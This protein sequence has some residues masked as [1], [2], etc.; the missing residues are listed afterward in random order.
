MAAS[1]GSVTF[2]ADRKDVE[3]I[4]SKCV[5]LGLSA[6][7]VVMGAAACGSSAP[8]GNTEGTGQGGAATSGSSSD[9][10]GG[11]HV[12]V[13]TS[14]TGGPGGGSSCTPSCGGKQCGDDGCGSTCGICAGGSNCTASN[15]CEVA[16]EECP[17]SGDGFMR[18]YPDTWAEGQCIVTWQCGNCGDENQSVLRA[19]SHQ[20]GNVL[21][22]KKHKTNGQADFASGGFLSNLGVERRESILFCE[23][24]PSGSDCVRI[25]VP[26]CAPYL[27]KPS[28]SILFNWSFNGTPVRLRRTGTKLWA[29]SQDP[30]NPSSWGFSSAGWLDASGGLGVQDAGYFC[31]EATQ[32]AGAPE[33][34][35]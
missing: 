34:C 32:P 18:S 27:A 13:S 14:S 16:P 9:G 19:H 29:E 28:C 22:A 24:E 30:N 5:Y 8:G 23:K 20:P 10:V 35:P 33:A 31:F 7:G 3:M 1:L 12:N 11:S 21:Y 15:Q 26:D 6:L 4:R 2:G 17:T 25:P